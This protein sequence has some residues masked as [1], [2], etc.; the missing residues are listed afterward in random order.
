MIIRRNLEKGDPMWTRKEL[1][2]KAKDVLRGN[3]WKALLVGFVMALVMGNG[4][5]WATERGGG[6]GGM[7]HIKPSFLVVGFLGLFIFALAF[8]I[9]LTYPLEVGGRRYFIKSA[10]Y[11]DNSK[12]FRFAYS[13]EHILDVF[14]GMFRRDVQLFLWFLLL[15]IPGIVKLYAYRFVP[16]ILA[17]NPGIG[18]G[19]A[20]AISDEMTKGH[21]FD[22][23]VL[24][25]S[26]LGWLF[27]GALAFGIG[28]FFVNPYVFATEAELY[29]KLR[30][31]A[32]T[33]GVC[34]IDEF[35]PQ[36]PH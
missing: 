35:E 6:Q 1:K 33:R 12:C 2:S 22:M 19:R 32:L 3:Y 15:I 34:T 16:H 36:T 17:E 18:S 26:F 20:I 25:L 31:N 23:F 13:S 5:N 10:L 30:D 29:L 24:D 11:D 28:V 9:L 27:L 7:V 14:K 21:K 8:R 4:S